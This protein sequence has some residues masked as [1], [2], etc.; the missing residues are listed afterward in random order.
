MF[1]AASKTGSQPAVA[2]NYIEDVFST[3]LYTGNGSTQTITNGIDLAGEGGMVWIKS[4]TD[5][6]SWHNLTDTV[7]GA[8]QNL[9]SNNTGAQF[10]AS[11]GQDFASFNSNGFSLGA[12]VVTGT[13]NNTQPFCSWTFREQ[14]KFFDIVTFT[15]NGTAGRTISHNLGSVPGM[16]ILKSTTDANPWYTYH[17]SEPTKYGMLN[18]TAVFTTTSAEFVFGNN[19]VTVAPT[20]TVFTVGAD[21]TVNASGQTY[22]AYLFAHDAGGF[23]TSGTDNVISCGTFTTDA[24][25][26]YSVNLG[27]EAQYVLLKRTNGTGD[28]LILDVMRGAAVSANTSQKLRANTSAAEVTDFVLMSPKADGFYADSS[29]SNLSGSSNYIYMAIRR[30]MKVPTTGTSVFSPNLYTEIVA[31]PTVLTS[32]FATDLNFQAR[33]AASPSGFYWTDRLRGSTASANNLLTSASTAAEATFG[34]VPSSFDNNTG[35]VIKEAFN[36]TSGAT[37]IS[38]QFRR[39]SGFFDEVCYTGTGSYDGQNQPHNLG[40]VPELIIVKSR[41]GTGRN[42][43]VYSAALGATKYLSLNLLNAEAA[44]YT[45]WNNTTPTSSFF[46]VNGS[47]ETGNTNELY[48]A[49]LFAT[50]AGVSKVGSYTGNGGTQAI[51]CGFTGGARFVLIKRTDST[52]GWYVYDTARG[53]TTLTDP[54]LLLNSTAA[55]AATLGSVTTTAGGFTVDA[56]ILA[57]INTNAASYIFLAIA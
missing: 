54:Y 20:S 46:T 1:S 2:A 7:R 9:A 24:S 26:G 38:Y 11:A 47:N 12:S 23:G 44:N 6:G 41:N 37:D 10:A 25:G 40:V 39:A 18:S 33:N 57:A 49:Y 14:A 27:Y 21:S 16:I 15:G 55:E 3:Y 13:N 5:G 43:A 28:W 50:C 19:T 52:G 4:R 45:F 51:A 17:R 30:P 31:N 29:L 32:G 8:T 53:M 42:W 36:N 22:I 48:V 34:V 56:S 35:I